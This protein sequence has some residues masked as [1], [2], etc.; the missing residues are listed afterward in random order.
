MFG[1][2]TDEIEVQLFTLDDPSQF[3]PTYECWTVRREAW[4]PE[5][6]FKQY[7]RDRAGTG[8]EA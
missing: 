4:L 2:W 8:R 6:G 7:E 5:F 3:K 1:R